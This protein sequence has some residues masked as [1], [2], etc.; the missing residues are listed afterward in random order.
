MQFQLTLVL[1][2]TSLSIFSQDQALNDIKQIVGLLDKNKIEIDATSPSE[3]ATLFKI[4]DVDTLYMFQDQEYEKYTLSK[5]FSFYQTQLNS[6]S[7]NTFHLDNDLTLIKTYA[8]NALKELKKLLGEPTASGDSY[9]DWEK[10]SYTITFSTFDDGYSFYID[11]YIMDNYEYSDE[12]VGDFYGLSADLEQNLIANITNKQLNIGTSSPEE[13]QTIIGDS[14]SNFSDFDGISSVSIISYNN[15][16][17]AEILI[18]YFYDCPSALTM[19]ELDITD[20]V[21]LFNTS[22]SIQEQTKDQEGFDYITWTYSDQ[23]IELV[24][25]SDGYSISFRKD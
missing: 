20:I 18:D 10:E 7:L 24:G 9:Y 6:I 19:L 13:I 2:F 17:L 5:S 23:M 12:C 11:S 4:K 14:I 3:I 25:Y 16:K 8:S 15:H 1:L 21:T 22:F